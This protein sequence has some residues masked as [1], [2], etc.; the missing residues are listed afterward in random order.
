MAV[1]F[2]YL[3]S[4]HIGMNSNKREIIDF[5]TKYNVKFLGVILSNFLDIISI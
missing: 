5:P 1:F 2:V 3:K 4:L